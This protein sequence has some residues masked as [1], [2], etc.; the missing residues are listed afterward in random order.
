MAPR[1]K[2]APE[3]EP[4]LKDPRD[5]SIH[6]D[7]VYAGWESWT[8]GRRYGNAVPRIFTPPLRE[9]TPETSLGFELIDFA[10]DVLGVQLYPWQRWLAIHL[11]ELTPADRLRFSTVLILVARQNGKSTFVAVLTLYLMI[12]QGW[13]LILGTAQDLGT[14]EEVWQ[15]TLDLLQ[16]DEELAALVAK[17]KRTNG[18]T[19]FKLATNERYVVKAASRKAG[20]GMSSNLVVLDELREQQNWLAWAAITKTTNAQE[21]RLLVGLSNAGDITSVVLRHFR[22][23]AHSTLGDPDG[24]VPDDYSTGPTT[25]DLVDV[26]PE[27][28]E[29]ALDEMALSED[30]LF[31]AE[32]SAKPGCPKTD[33]VGMAQANPSVGHRPAMM[34]TLITDAENDPEWVYRTECLCQWPEST[35]DGPFP[36]G[37]WEL[38]LNRPIEK[39]DGSLELDPRDV[40]VGQLVACVDQSHDRA[41]TS[42]AVA[43]K[44]ADGQDQVEVIAQRA[45]TEWVA[46]FLMERKDRIRRVTGQTRGAP[47]SP[48]MQA[49]KDSTKFTI[50]VEDWQSGD[51]MG[52][53]AIL[54]DS[55][56]DTTVRH[57]PQPP[58]DLAAATAVMKNLAD[59]FVLDRRQSTAD[60][61]P[62][63]AFA[64]ALWLSRKFKA[65]PPPLVLP[66]LVS[67]GESSPTRESFDG[68]R[69]NTADLMRLEF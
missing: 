37:A 43:G 59:G 3:P 34:G 24:I 20:R 57:N 68:F 19:E 28:A 1:K 36:A 65:A 2:S 9:L 35:M 39:P 18:K 63:M 46:G 32:W 49:L 67:E 29:F 51:L 54:Y 38:G 26:D 5:G 58:L 16:E 7:Y 66:S 31:L 4:K 64:G 60:V 25:A 15:F 11:L 61:S 50:P 12:V 30:R 62:L 52:A 23:R 42:V 69:G 53:C 10:T 45:G 13:P 44:R 8:P 47:V 14:A 56:R 17:V 40:L 22:L 55:V 6:D 48:L 27:D 33:R 21:N 41:L